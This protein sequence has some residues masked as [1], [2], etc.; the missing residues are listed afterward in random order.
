MYTRP[1]YMVASFVLFLI[2]LTFP[3]HPSDNDV[4]RYTRWLRLLFEILPIDFD[5]V[6]ALNKLLPTQSVIKTRRQFVD[7]AF[8]LHDEI[9]GMPLDRANTL[10]FFDQ[11]RASDCNQ[12]EEEEESKKE[13]GCVHK[14]RTSNNACHIFFHKDA[15]AL[16]GTK[17]N[18]ILDSSLVIPT[19]KD[20]EHDTL[21][22]ENAF[23]SCIFSAKWFLLHMIASKYPV[24]TTPETSHTYMEWLQLFGNVL[25]CFVCRANFRNNLKVLGLED[26]EKNFH[27]RYAFEMFIYRLHSVVNDMLGQPNIA[28]HEMKLLY[29]KLCND[30]KNDYI[31]TIAIAPIENA[32]RF[33]LI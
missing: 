11:L 1:F 18:F 25:A 15:S 26:I 5:C 19:Q 30:V 24:H 13:A 21:T 23:C 16:L 28:F 33:F 14:Q 27:T 9:I 4:L 32:I 29:E 22:N 17:N 7:L 20:I 8:A 3:T 31:V 12:K 10:V 6:V 2:A